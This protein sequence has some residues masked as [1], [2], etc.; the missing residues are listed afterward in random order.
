MKQP[1]RFQDSNAG[2][3]SAYYISSCLA[4]LLLI[5]VC[6]STISDIRG[7]SAEISREAVPEKTVFIVVDTT[8]IAPAADGKLP[9]W[10]EFHNTYGL[11]YT[12]LKT[13]L[14]HY[15]RQTSSKATESDPL[16]QNQQIKIYLREDLDLEKRDKP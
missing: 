10:L 2:Q 5:Y 8:L 3:V 12:Y 6:L 7:N 13:S 15:N 16:P 4:P 1:S 14:E 9:T 11:E